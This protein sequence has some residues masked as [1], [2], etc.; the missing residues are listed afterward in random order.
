M[1]HE[2]APRLRRNP[3]PSIR[4]ALLDLLRQLPELVWVGLSAESMVMTPRVSEAFV[5][6]KQPITGDDTALQ[7]VQGAVKVV[8]EKYWRYFDH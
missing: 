5:E 3:H 4:A 7:L 2:T 6:N 8:S 1:L